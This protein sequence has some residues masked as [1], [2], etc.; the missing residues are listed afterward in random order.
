MS[1]SGTDD[2][3]RFH[4]DLERHVR[5]R[6]NDESC[7][8]VSGPYVAPGDMWRGEIPRACATARAF[9]A[10]LN[11]RYGESTWCSREWWIFEE[12]LRRHDF[13]D[14][15]APSLLLPVVWQPM[16]RPIPKVIGNRQ[17]TDWYLSSGAAS[18]GIL[19]L[20]YRKDLQPYHEACHLLA[21]L[22]AE[23]VRGRRGHLP[24]LPPETRESLTQAWNTTP[25]APGA[26]TPPKA[27]GRPGEWERLD[28]LEKVVLVLAGAPRLSHVAE[29][30]G[31][32]GRLSALREG[33]LA[34]RQWALTDPVEPGYRSL[35]EHLEQR[36]GRV[37]A[38]RLLEE[39]LAPL[40]AEGARALAQVV[41]EHSYTPRTG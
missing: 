24:P 40:T 32:L 18:E 6:L 33:M 38:Y 37:R 25:D 23:A 11:D 16:E 35:V 12:R 5:I 17:R 27:M 19:G 1:K 21:G 7:R 28:P 8:G 15:P 2:V 9:V 14:G 41:D 30:T 4:R 13:G 22:V 39:A 26:W 20:M 31:F 3:L 34:P 10:L 29:W 36:H